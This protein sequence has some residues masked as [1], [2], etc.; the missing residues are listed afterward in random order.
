M[1]NVE[2]PVTE[3]SR[4]LPKKCVGRTSRSVFFFKK[5]WDDITRS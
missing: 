3:I 4:S 5:K 2:K 1:K